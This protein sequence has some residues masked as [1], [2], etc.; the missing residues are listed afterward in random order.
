MGL[1]RPVSRRRRESAPRRLPAVG[2]HRWTQLRRPAPIGE[3]IDDLRW[4]FAG[5]TMATATGQVRGALPPH[6]PVPDRRGNE[7]HSQ[8]MSKPDGTTRGELT[9][10]LPLVGRFG[11][12]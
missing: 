10:V 12:W 6:R 1:D 11:P 9:A 5:E 3:W 8:G 4:R 2:L 7:F